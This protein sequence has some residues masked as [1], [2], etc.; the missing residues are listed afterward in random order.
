MGNGDLTESDLRGDRSD[1][2]LVIVEGVGVGE[3]D[4]EASDARVEELLQVGRDLRD[5]CDREKGQLQIAESSEARSPGFLSMRTA[6]PLTPLTIS[7][8]WSE[9]TLPSASNLTVVSAKRGSE[10]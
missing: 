8:S 2:R 7:P 6:S 5:I 3:A 1:E 9:M 4:G 10:V